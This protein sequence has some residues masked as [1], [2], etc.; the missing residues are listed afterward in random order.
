MKEKNFRILIPA[1]NSERYIDDLFDRIEKMGLLDK[2]VVVN[3]GSKDN[4]VKICNNR[5]VTVL[6]NERN[7]GKGS[8]LKKGFKFM[9]E[10]NVEFFLT[11]DSDLQH[12]VKFIPEFI[13]KY[14]ETGAD[15]IVGNRLGETSTMPIERVF[16]NRTTSFIVSIISGCKIPDSQSGYRLIKTSALNDLTLT[17]DKFEMES[18]ILIKAGRKGRK[19]DS[20]PISALYE[21]AHSSISVFK[22]TY[23]FIRLVIRSLIIRH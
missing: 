16:S 22:D 12:D 4:T 14:E 6:S 5:G 15:I 7:G 23:R 20:V 2:V 19:I 18:E 17:C 3:D 10:N 9:V 11:I 21:G 1:Y 13:K 8:A